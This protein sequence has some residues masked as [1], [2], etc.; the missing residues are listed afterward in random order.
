[1]FLYQTPKNCLCLYD[2]PNIFFGFCSAHA[3]VTHIQ[4]SQK[5]ATTFCNL[6]RTGIF[7]DSLSQGRDSPVEEE[8]VD[9]HEEG[10][11][12]DVQPVKK[13]DTAQPPTC[14]LELKL[15]VPKRWSSLCYMIERCAIVIVVW[16]PFDVGCFCL[17]SIALVSEWSYFA[18]Q[19]VGF[20]AIS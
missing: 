12:G 5:V 8:E 10:D 20:V 14:V 11:P 9:W 18:F 16:D 1:M 7:A 17:F 15:L 13:G 19:I 4:S 3:F 2:N 6:Q